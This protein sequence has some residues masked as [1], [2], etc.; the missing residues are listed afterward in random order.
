MAGDPV[1][2]SQTNYGFLVEVEKESHS[3]N[4][5]R[6]KS[7]ANV[8]V[9]VSP[10]RTLNSC[11][12]VFWCRAH[13][14]QPDDDI[15]NE[16]TDQQVTQVKRILLEKGTKPSHTF[17]VTFGRTRLPSH[18]KIGY[19]SVAVRQYIPNPLRCFKCQKYGHG[20]NACKGT[21]TCAK[22]GTK[23]HTDET[24]EAEEPTCFNCLGKHCSIRTAIRDDANLHREN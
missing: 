10:H 13:E 19:M 3:R 18:L 21:I 17:I 14:G 11:R 8:P 20:S 5:L 4:L 22:C 23:N 6:A 24:C 2:V 9:I 16:L 12:G 1:K 15:K 7:L